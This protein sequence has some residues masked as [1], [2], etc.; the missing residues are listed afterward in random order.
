[1]TNAKSN[2][3]RVKQHYINYLFLVWHKLSQSLMSIQIE[4]SLSRESSGILRR[5]NNGGLNCSTA[6]PPFSFLHGQMCV[7]ALL[8]LVRT[9][10]VFALRAVEW[11]KK[12]QG[13]EN[14]F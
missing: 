1:M 12:M 10:R 14:R 9:E 11:R 6:R 8:G 3:I 4:T 5:D 7:C 2:S 13:L